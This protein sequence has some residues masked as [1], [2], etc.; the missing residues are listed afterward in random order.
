MLGFGGLTA[1]LLIALLVLRVLPIMP[2]ALG[3]EGK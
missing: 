3:A 2:T 1:A